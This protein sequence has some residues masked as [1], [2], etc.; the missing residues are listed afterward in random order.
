[1]QHYSGRVTAIELDQAGELAAWVACPP[2]AIPAPGRYLSAWSPEDEQ[3]VLATALFCSAA[4]GDQELNAGQLLPYKQ[5]LAA[6]AIPH[7]W[8]PGMALQLR[9]PLGRGFSIPGSARRVALAALGK[10]CE[11]L[12]PL[13]RLALAQDAAVALFTDAPVSALPAAIEI[14][15]LSSLGEAAPW[16]DYL[17]LDLPG[18]ELEQLRERLALPGGERLTYPAQALVGVDMPCAGVGVCGACWLPARRGIRLACS[19]GPVF[20]LDD[21]DW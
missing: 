21:L 10:T 4:S 13:A 5:F 9:G 2:A 14:H 20:D 6:G 18:S 11:R 1:M 17:A 16:T 19:D 7:S 15:P 8:A 12:L 3:A